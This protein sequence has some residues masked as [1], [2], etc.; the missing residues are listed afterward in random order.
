[1][2]S[3]SRLLT[4]WRL[5]GFLQFQSGTPFSL[6]ASEPEASSA[7]QY[8]NLARGSGGLYRLGFGRPSLCGTLDQLRQS[9]PDRTEQYFNPA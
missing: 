2:G 4:G 9:G 7:A 3:N 5:S 1:F 8:T 6:F